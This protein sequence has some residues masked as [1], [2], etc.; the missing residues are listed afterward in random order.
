M[1]SEKMPPNSLRL[2]MI[3]ISKNSKE[4]QDA[5]IHEII[6]WE[7]TADFKCC[8][9]LMYHVTLIKYSERKYDL[10]FQFDHSIFDLFSGQLIRTQLLRRYEELRQGNCNAMELSCNY[11]AYLDQIRKGPIGIT[12]EEF[13]EKFKIGAYGIAFS[14]IQQKIARRRMDRNKQVTCLVDVGELIDKNENSDAML[15]LAVVL[16]GMTLSKLLDV[17]TVAIDLLF[18]NRK[19]GKLKYN[20]VMGMAVDG[21]PL[22]FDITDNSLGEIQS[23]LKKM[24]EDISRYNINFFNLVSNLKSFLKWGR[25]MQEVN[26]ASNSKM[27][28]SCLINYAGNVEDEYS[29]IWDY[30]TSD[31]EESNLNYA[32]YYVAVKSIDTKLE[33]HI[34]CSFEKDVERIKNIMEQQV[35]TLISLASASN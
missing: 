30:N 11:K 27:F 25:V 28:S 35:R 14:E 24:L 31:G 8:N 20:D 32:D 22:V 18:Q 17:E 21:I 34:I 1:W 3:D 6:E 9:H 5:V 23:K 16:S 12:P 19:Y 13:R 29:R 26:Q 2:P 15:E 7:K 4:S 10:L 33:F